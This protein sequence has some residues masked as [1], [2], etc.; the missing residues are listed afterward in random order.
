[1]VFTKFMYGPESTYGTA[2]TRTTTLGRVQSYDPDENNS[3]IYERGLGEGLNPVKTY[4]GPYNCGASVGFN[5][6]NF[7]FLKHWI[8]PK[9]GSDPWTLTEAIDIEANETSLQPFT[10]EASN[11]TESTDDVHIM[12]GCIGNAFS[13]TASI[14]GILSCDASFF[15]Q[16]TF[17][18]TTATSY[19]ALT[20]DSYVA[21]NGTWKWGATPTEFTSVRSFTL[22]YTN[23]L[24]PDDN[25]TLDSRFTKMPVLSAGRIYNG[26][27]TVVLNQALAQTI[28]TNFYGQTPSSGPVGGT[29]DA[30]P[31]ADL[32][33]KIEFVK[34]DEYATLWL[35]QA[36]IDS[37]SEPVAVGGGVVLLNFNFTARQGRS[38]TPIVWGAN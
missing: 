5:V 22:N 15:G 31:T 35:D 12:S 19:T 1:M 38:N 28:Y 34:S 37:I 13:L 14:G 33:F 17:R 24:S 23:G 32:E 20:E 36:S 3:M 10:F 25:R 2:A 9:T 7:D 4:Y 6:V 30:A 16:K 26:D 11:T 8:G 27:L 29:T 21:I 18:D